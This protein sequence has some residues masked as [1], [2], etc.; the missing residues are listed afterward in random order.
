[1]VYLI[2]SGAKPDKSRSDTT[3]SS[4]GRTRDEIEYL[5]EARALTE[6]F[7]DGRILRAGRT[8]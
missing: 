2:P 1:M 3:A 8:T 7:F 5:E 4:P 6:S